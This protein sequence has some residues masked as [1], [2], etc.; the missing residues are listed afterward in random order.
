M[1]WTGDFS[2]RDFDGDEDM[3]FRTVVGFG[4]GSLG[5]FIYWKTKRRTRKHFSVE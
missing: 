2:E 3:E 4:R 5:A 1:A